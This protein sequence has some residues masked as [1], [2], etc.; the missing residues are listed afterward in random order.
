MLTENHCLHLV[1]NWS[2]LFTLF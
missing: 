2:S 1:S